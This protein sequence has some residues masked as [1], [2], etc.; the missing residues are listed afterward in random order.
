LIIGTY[1][2]ARASI[3]GPDL[4]QMVASWGFAVSGRTRRPHRDSRLEYKVFW[5]DGRA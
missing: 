3:G 5:I 2:E 1:N 4:E